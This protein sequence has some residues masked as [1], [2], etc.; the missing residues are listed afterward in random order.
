MLNNSFIFF[1]LCFLRREREWLESKHG[2][3]AF[4]FLFP[5]IA[6]VFPSACPFV[7]SVARCIANEDHNVLTSMRGSQVS[8]SCSSGGL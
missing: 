5:F 4:L 8:S 6:I 7:C 2:E 3:I 1:F